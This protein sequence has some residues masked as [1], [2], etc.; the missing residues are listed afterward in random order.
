M[1]EN[2]LMLFEGN[3][4]IVETINGEP[5]FEI[6]STGAALGYS[7]PNS[8][9]NNYPYKSRI[10]NT[11]KMPKSRLVNTMFTNISLKRRH[12]ITATSLHCMSF[13]DLKK[14]NSYDSFLN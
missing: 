3:S 12:K 8:T 10:D 2:N 5:Y 11:I 7:R 13:T 9:G 6:Y 1:S 4:V 14:Q